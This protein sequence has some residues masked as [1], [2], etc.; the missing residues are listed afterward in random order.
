MKKVESIENLFFRNSI[1]LLCIVDSHGVFREINHEFTRV[2]GYTSSEI[3]GKN[4]IGFVHPDDKVLMRIDSEMLVGSHRMENIQSR[5]RQKGGSYCWLDWRISLNDGFIYAS[6]RGI[7]GKENG[8][9]STF[10]SE[11]GTDITRQKTALDALE[12][13]EKKYRLLF[14]NMTSGFAL[15]QVIYDYSGNPV[16][17]RYIEA[18]PAFGKLTGLESVNIIGKTIREVV[19]DIEEYWIQTFGKVAMTGE[20]VSY[21]NYSPTL[22]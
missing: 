13:S 4:Y 11:V 3:I 5:F 20:P 16:D 15:H 14:E 12:E 1:D 7:T 18:N 2:L 22:G 10:K 9:P 6:A 19:P 17:Y 8:E 21:I